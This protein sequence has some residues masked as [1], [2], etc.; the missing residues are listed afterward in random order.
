[1]NIHSLN[2]CFSVSFKSMFSVSF[3]SLLCFCYCN[4]IFFI[5][6]KKFSKMTNT[7][8]NKVEGRITYASPI[9]SFSYK[10]GSPEYAQHF[11]LTDVIK[12]GNIENGNN[13]KILNF[14]I[15]VWNDLV[16][17]NLLKVNS[18]YIISNF[19]IKETELSRR[20]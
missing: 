12:K 8:F 7:L 9:S 14:K 17:Q 15:V 3:A 5:F 16:S 18:F 20:S 13:E 2:L 1:M 6:R 10:N 19:N 11:I 4:C